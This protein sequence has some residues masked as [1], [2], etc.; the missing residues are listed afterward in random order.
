MKEVIAVV[1]RDR[2]RGTLDVLEDAGFVPSA[3]K[4]LGKGRERGL[5]YPDGSGS[6]RFLPKTL[7]A[8]AVEDGK[9]ERA[10]RVIE[11]VNRTGEVGD[12]KVF[13]SPVEAAGDR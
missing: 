8:L 6:I 5:R 10:I 12:G 9:V 3:T 4:A 7:I 1:R 13:V 11:E 2:G